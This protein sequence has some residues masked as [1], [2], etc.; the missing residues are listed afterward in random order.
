MKHS[1]FQLF[2]VLFHSEWNEFLEKENDKCTVCFWWKKNLGGDSR[3]DPIEERI[4]L[5]VI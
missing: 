1:G 5:S 4:F 3:S 2:I